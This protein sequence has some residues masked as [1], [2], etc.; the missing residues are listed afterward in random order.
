MIIE[1]N[2]KISIKE[3]CELLEISEFTY[4]YQPQMESVENLNL[5]RIM[6]ELYLEHPYY[7]S[8]KMTAVLRRKGFSVNRK[9]VQRL[10][11][12]MGIVAIYPK[13]RKQLYSK[14]HTIY[15]YLLRNRIIQQVNEVWC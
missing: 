2:E 8:R 3:Q 11:N 12:K 15:P 14:E 4:Y 9:R 6:D 13:K 5:M 7:G 10:M 1:K